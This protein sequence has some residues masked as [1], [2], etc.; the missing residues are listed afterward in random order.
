[1]KTDFYGV[2]VDL[3]S[4]EDVITNVKQRFSDE[5][6]TIVL[7]LNA[8]CYNI[9]SKNIEYRNVLNNADFVLNDGI[10]VELGG[11]VRG[12]RFKDN[13]NGTDLIPQILN[14]LSNDGKI[15]LLGGRENVAE[16]ARDE[17]VKAKLNVVGF[18]N[19]FFHDD[20]KILNEIIKSDA[21][22]LVLGMGVPKQEIW[23]NDNIESLSNIKLAIA[24]GAILDFI[25]KSIPRAPKWMRDIRLE[26]LY[27]L[28][29]EPKRMWQRY[30][31]GNVKF[32][33]YIMRNKV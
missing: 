4:K 9:S 31:I 8:H 2:N 24:G 26:W 29:L 1:M 7:F 13:L 3:L 33:Y 12:I 22:I 30:L 10:G 18:H 11:R 14:E 21:N 16:K 15:F 19:G 23:L 17:L 20:N 5:I 6:K 32:V 25:S 28:M 27:R